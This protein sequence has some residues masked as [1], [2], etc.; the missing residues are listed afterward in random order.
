MLKLLNL[1]LNNVLNPVLF[2]KTYFKDYNDGN[3]I[4]LNNEYVIEKINKILSE[5]ENDI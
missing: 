1:D 3:K 2:I 5:N 4:I